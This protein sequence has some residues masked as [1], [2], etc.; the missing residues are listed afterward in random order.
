MERIKKVPTKREYSVGKTSGEKGQAVV[1]TRCPLKTTPFDI[2]VSIAMRVTLSSIQDLFNMQATC[3]LFAA[4]CRF[5]G[6]YRHALVLELPVACFL[7]RSRQ[8]AM[9]FVSRCAIARN[10]AALLRQGMVALFWHGH[11]RAGIQTVTEAAELGDVEAC[12]LCAMPLLSLDDKDDDDIRRRLAFFY[13]VRESGAVER[14]R[15]VFTQVFASPWLEINLTDPAEAVACRSGGCPTCG[16]MSV[17]S[18]LFGV[19]CVQCLAEDEVRNFLTS[20][21]VLTIFPNPDDRCRSSLVMLPNRE[22]TL[23]T[24]E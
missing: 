13:V 15:K 23:F 1:R 16:T 8:A 5:D 21:Y 9:G 10:P 2:W 19:T 17:A 22:S 11:C 24:N 12:Y 18:D 4:V 14:C 20:V 3:R 7:Y 6:V